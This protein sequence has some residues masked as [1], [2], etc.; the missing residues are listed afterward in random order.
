MVTSPSGRSR[1]KS[2]SL[3]AGTVPDPSFFTRAGQEQRIPSSRSV[4]VSTMRSP[5]AS[6]NTLDKIGMVVFFSTTPCDRLSSRTKSAL[7]TVNSIRPQLL[8]TFP[9]FKMST[10][11][12]AFIGPVQMLEAS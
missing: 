7:L 2:R 8:S 5:T 11:R 4:A 1:T 9:V 6:I 10:L 3:R 12:T